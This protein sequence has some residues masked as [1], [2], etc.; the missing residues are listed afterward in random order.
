MQLT[1]ADV[2]RYLRWTLFPGTVR[3]GDAAHRRCI[4]ASDPSNVGR[5]YVLHRTVM[6]HLYAGRVR[7]KMGGTPDIRPS[8]H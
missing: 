7:R 6:H 2:H 1:F 5:Y 3:L 4:A 8:S